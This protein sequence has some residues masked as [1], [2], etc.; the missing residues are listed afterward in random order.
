MIIANSLFTRLAHNS[1]YLLSELHPS[2]VNVITEQWLIR[3]GVQ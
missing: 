2:W 3:Y 1:P